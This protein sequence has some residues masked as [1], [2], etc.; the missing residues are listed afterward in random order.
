MHTSVESIE[1]A[2]PADLV[3]ID[4]RYLW[5][6]YTQE[7]T[8]PDPLFIAS[9][10]GSSLYDGDGNAY[11]DLVSSWW[12]TTHG[13]AHPAIAAAIA[14]QATTMEQ[15]IFAGITHAPA[16][17][18]AARLAG[19]LPAGLSRVFYS[20]DGSTAV[21]VAMKLCCQYWLNQ[22]ER[23]PRFLVFE[24]A[25]H[26]DTVGAMSAGK[27]SGFFDAFDTMMFQVDTVPFPM[28]WWQDDDV[29]QREQQTLDAIDRYFRQHGRANGSDGSDCAAVMIE[30]LIQGSSGIRMCRPEFL[31]ALEAKVRAQG[32]LLIFDEV[33]TGFGRTGSLFACQKAGVTPDLICLSKGL[34]GGFL[35]MSATVCQEFIYRAFLGDS[36]DRAFAHG[37]SFTGNPLGCAAALASLELFA[38]EHTLEACAAIEAVH[39]ERLADL[40]DHPRVLRPRLTGTIAAFDMSAGEGGYTSAIGPRLKAFFLQRKLLIRPLGNVVYLM[41]PYCTTAEELHRGW[42]GIKAALDE[43]F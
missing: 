17:R 15:V 1:S 42:D 31:R 5:H 19:E 30:P 28:T 4:R 23:R 33:M 39:R 35:P 29:E 16:I 8:A 41:P 22:G 37:H 32:V 2:S 13:H 21:E 26:G 36:F 24:G 7:Q 3:A 38:T 6:P 12:V 43:V 9:A 11:L 18:L 10:R 14:A 40:A 20:D 34:T 27:S 25:Y